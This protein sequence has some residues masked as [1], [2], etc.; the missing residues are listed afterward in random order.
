M[1]KVK[2]G[3][4][5]SAVIV[6]AVAGYFIYAYIFPTMSNKAAKEIYGGS[7]FGT[8]D[9]S[10]VDGPGFFAYVKKFLYAL[11]D[12][13]IADSCTEGIYNGDQLGT[14]EEYMRKGME[15]ARRVLFENKEVEEDLEE[16]LEHEGA[17]IMVGIKFDEVKNT[18]GCAN[19]TPKTHDLSDAVS[20]T[21]LRILLKEKLSLD[22]FKGYLDKLQ[23]DSNEH[24]KNHRERIG[25]KEGIFILDGDNSNPVDLYDYIRTVMFATS[26]LIPLE[27]P[28]AN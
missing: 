22:E 19:A 1:M 23:D 4:V 17:D 9:N 2:R 15:K 20:R 18:E 21:F 16:I 10:P 28:V 12:N 27:V 7:K 3:G 6:M 11:D 26:K 25:T 13:V 24:T 5:I 14:K 8:V